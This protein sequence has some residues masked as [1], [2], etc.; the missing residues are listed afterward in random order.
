MTTPLLTS[1]ELA[2]LKKLE[3][4]AT[5]APWFARSHGAGQWDTPTLETKHGG[6][7]ARFTHYHPMKEDAVLLVEA[8]NALPRM[9][10]DHE[11]L[12]SEVGLLR[13]DLLRLSLHFGGAAVKESKERMGEL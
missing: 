6:I 5:R 3:S 10:T 2:V 4:E 7:L 1:E 9:L 13:T 11:R 8:R 12:R